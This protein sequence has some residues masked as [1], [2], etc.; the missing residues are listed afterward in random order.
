VALETSDSCLV[1]GNP[2]VYLFDD[3]ILI[4]SRE[5]CFLFD[6]QSGRFIRKIGHIGNDPKGYRSAD[7]QMV[8][9]SGGLIYF[10]G[11]G[12]ELVCYNTDGLFI[13]RIPIPITN[14]GFTM[15]DYTYL[16]KDT[17]AG[18]Y[19]NLTGNEKNRLIFF[20][21]TGERID[22]LPNRQESPSFD[23]DKI[24]VFNGE[25]VAV[26]YTPAAAKGML[27]LS[28]KDPETAS[29]LF[30][31]HTFWRLN[32]TTY[33]KETYNDTIFRIEGTTLVPDRYIDL[34]EYHWPYAKR[35][36]RKQDKNIFI[37]QCL[38]NENLL[39]F[40][41]ITRLYSEDGRKQYNA[42]YNKVNQ[43]LTIGDLTKGITDDITRFLPLQPLYV[44]SVTGE[45]AGIIP[46]AKVCEWF[47]NNNQT[48]ALPES[49]R[50]L[51]NTTEEDNP[52][53]VLMN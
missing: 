46:A 11:F 13:G 19:H 20:T 30:M 8:D 16:N 36:D 51:K 1:G 2:S 43:T 50:S 45:L 12:T 42:I 9:E 33:F 28:D 52:V 18:F 47:E 34:G 21:K 10:P 32:Q 27:I 41:F 17:L 25:G 22:E 23:I 6:K 24:E 35:F 37:T 5:E 7:C 14:D 3:K 39:L 53:I 29:T 26:S 38:E 40:R 44:S 49:I 48:E 31:K 15:L 4:S